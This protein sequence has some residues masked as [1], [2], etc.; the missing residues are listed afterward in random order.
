MTNPILRLNC[1]CFLVWV[2]GKVALVTLV[3]ALDDFS[4][5]EELAE[6][7]RRKIG[8][9]LLGDSW[10]VDRVAVLDED[11]SSAKVLPTQKPNKIAIA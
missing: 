9:G 8:S 5:T 11:R 3:R 7:I 4:S 1:F 10:V 6:Q 2:T